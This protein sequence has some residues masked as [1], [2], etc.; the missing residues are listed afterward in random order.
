MP[1]PAIPIIQAGVGLAQSIFGGSKAKKAQKQLEG[2][3]TPTY[4]GSESIMDYY[5]KALARNNANPYQSQQYQYA[6][7]AAARN[8]AAGIGALQDRRSAVGGISRLTAIG[9]DAALKAGVQAEQQ[10]NQRFG[11]LGQAAGMKTADEL[12]QFQQNKLAPYEQKY[13]LLSAKAGAANNTVNS[14]MSNIFGGLNSAGQM[15]MIDKM[16]GSNDGT[17]RKNSG[18]TLESFQKD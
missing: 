9:N 12:R 18:L 15:Q 16:Y 2:M 11:Q 1:I 3:Q 5:N 6:T 7:G 13:N 10:Q 4:G 17:K 8:Q 14:G